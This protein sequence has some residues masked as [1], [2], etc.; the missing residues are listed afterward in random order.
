MERGVDVDAVLVVSFGGPEGPAD[1][2]P[3][4]DNVLRGRPVPPERRRQVAAHY[5][6]LGGI[7]P[8]NGANRQ[9]VGALDTAL[10]ARGSDLPVYWGNRNWHPY[11]ID[12]MRAMRDDGVR[13]AA[14]FVT[15]AYSSFSSCRQYRDNIDDAR[16]ATGDGAPRVTKL[17]PFFNHPGF[18]EPLADGL[19][20]GLTEAG[21]GAPVLMTA[22]SI[23]AAQAATCDYERQ[24]LETARLVAERAGADDSQVVYQSRS[25]PPTQPWLGPDVTEA[26]AGLPVGERKAVVVTPI[27]FVSDHMEVVYDLDRVA[28]ATAA[29]RDLWLVRTPTPGSD[30]RF[31]EMVCDLVDEV[32]DPAAARPLALGDLGPV[33]CP[34]A[35]NCC[36]RPG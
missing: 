30:P 16:A 25:G 15:S 29:Q 32:R 20:A 24:L 11:L 17:R 1:V 27:G 7:S 9:L 2:D 22:H 6:E 35:P 13:H 36:P 5:L 12:T 28:A 26:I 23:P 4:L 18:V 21:P 31:V 34:C 10:K 19:H 33:P 3:F 8:I 14:A